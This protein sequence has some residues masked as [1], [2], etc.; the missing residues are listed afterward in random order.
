MVPLFCS[1]SE[2]RFLRAKVRFNHK[3]EKSICHSLRSKNHVVYDDALLE[4]SS[5]RYD[6]PVAEDLTEDY[7]MLLKELKAVQIEP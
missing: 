7:G 3:L 5:S 4:E 1:G 2:H 6:W